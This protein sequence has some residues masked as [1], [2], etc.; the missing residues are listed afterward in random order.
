M[1]RIC[2]QE[3]IIDNPCFSVTREKFL[4]LNSILCL[5]FTYFFMYCTLK[6]TSFFLFLKIFI[7]LF[8]C[9]AS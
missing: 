3:I 2:S 6:I 7:Y 4:V 5:L 8:G 9:I 1:N